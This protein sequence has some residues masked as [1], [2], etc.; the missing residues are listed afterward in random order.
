MKLFTSLTLATMLS[1]VPAAS[2]A[3]DKKMNGP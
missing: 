2:L 1:L 3:N